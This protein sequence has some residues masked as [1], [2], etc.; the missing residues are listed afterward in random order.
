MK[1]V[2]CD[3]WLARLLLWDNYGTIMLFGFVLSKKTELSAT[4]L[5]HEG[6]H[7]RQYGEVT[8]AALIVAVLVGVLTGWWWVV[9][10]A[11]CAYYIWYGIEYALIR[12]LGLRDDVSQNGA[13]HDV[14]FEEEAY[15]HQGDELY[16]ECRERFAWVK[17]LRIGSYKK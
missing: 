12:L 3:N 17:Y 6:T 1:T 13:Y 8:V 16:L 4:S 9:L 15:A 14:A 11:L 5:R 7:Q 10:I 2:F